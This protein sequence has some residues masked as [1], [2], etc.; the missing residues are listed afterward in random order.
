MND[1]IGPVERLGIPAYRYGREGLHGI[2]LPCIEAGTPA[3]GGRC[4]TQFPTSSALAASFNRSL[5]FHVGRA[6]GTPNSHFHSVI[7]LTTTTRSVGS[8]Q[9]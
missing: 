8:P 1:E 3:E 2:D 6:Q 5:W 4:F 9:N 7:E